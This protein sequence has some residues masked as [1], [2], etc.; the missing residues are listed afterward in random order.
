MLRYLVFQLTSPGD[1]WEM[2]LVY[3]ELTIPTFA[4]EAFVAAG[5]EPRRQFMRTIIAEILDC[6]PEAPAVARMAAVSA[7][8]GPRVEPRQ[9]RI[10]G[11]R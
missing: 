8:P 10:P 5:I 3:R 7:S 9:G 4:H 11:H 2:R 1:A 6:P